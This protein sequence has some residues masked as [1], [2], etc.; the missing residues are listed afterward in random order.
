L[1]GRVWPSCGLGGSSTGGDVSVGEDRKLADDELSGGAF[2]N[3]DVLS[4]KIT[5]VVAAVIDDD[6]AR[7]VVGDRCGVAHVKSRALNPGY[8]YRRA[9]FGSQRNRSH[10]RN[11]CE[12]DVQPPVRFFKGREA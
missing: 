10:V 2:V 8:S 9:L 12:F 4:P 7:W 3:A 6:I 11:L 5:G 1:I